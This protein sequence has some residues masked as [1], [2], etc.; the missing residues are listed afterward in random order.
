MGRGRHLEVLRED[1][2]RDLERVREGGVPEHV[3]HDRGQRLVVGELVE[4]LELLDRVVPVEEPRVALSH[5]ADRDPAQLQQRRLDPT[6]LPQGVEHPH[7]EAQDLLPV[8]DLG[9]VQVAV[10]VEPIGQP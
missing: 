4:L 6:A 8:E 10:A 9:E 5:R 2:A 7:P 1:E 3:L